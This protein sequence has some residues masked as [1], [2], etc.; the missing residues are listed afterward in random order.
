[1]RN[2]LHI[3]MGLTIHAWCL[4]R[5]RLALHTHSPLR[6]AF[7]TEEQIPSSFRASP[8]KTLSSPIVRPFSMCRVR[9]FISRPSRAAY[10]LADLY[11]YGFLLSEASLRKKLV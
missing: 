6:P 3:P 10:A 8:W 4:S 5:V 9:A 2:F 11:R 1:M 7:S